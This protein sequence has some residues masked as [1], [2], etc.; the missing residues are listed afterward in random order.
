MH[1]GLDAFDVPPSKPFDLAPQFNKS[2]NIIVI[3]NTEAVDY[4]EGFSYVLDHFLGV[5]LQILGVRDC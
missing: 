2:M 1:R 4:C 5:K 3:E